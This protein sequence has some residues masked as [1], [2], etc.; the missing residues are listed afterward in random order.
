MGDDQRPTEGDSRLRGT[1][2][3]INSAERKP[4]TKK[5]GKTNKRNKKEQEEKAKEEVEERRLILFT[6]RKLC[7]RVYA[8]TVIGEISRLKLLIK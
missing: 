6:A 1:Q 4:P 3:P 5:R 7:I 2:E 8:R